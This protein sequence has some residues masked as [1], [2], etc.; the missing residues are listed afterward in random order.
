[1]TNLS[2]A[3]RWRVAGPGTLSFRCPA[4][5]SPETA[6][7]SLNHLPDA[8]TGWGENLFKA[9]DNV[10]A[11]QQKCDFAATRSA[12]GERRMTVSTVMLHVLATFIAA[13][14]SWSFHSLTLAWT[15][16]ACL[17]AGIAAALIL[18]RRMHSE[19]SWVK[20]RRA[21]EF[22]RSALATW[23]LPRTKHRS[24]LR[25]EH[26]L[27]QEVIEWHSRVSFSESH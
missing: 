25:T 20:C 13:A 18:R 4:P 23:A 27:L 15:K 3:G 21:A 17:G 19:R 6:L 7:N 11:F 8:T 26:A 16:F 14:V 10:F 2:C 12:S 1:V 9:P 22:C 5:S 24:V